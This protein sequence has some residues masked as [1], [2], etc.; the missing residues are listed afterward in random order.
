MDVE[1]PPAL[2]EVPFS[3]PSVRGAVGG[4]A[5]SSSL[6]LLRLNEFESPEGADAGVAPF[7]EPKPGRPVLRLFPFDDTAPL[8]P[9]V[10]FRFASL[11]SDA[12]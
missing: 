9:A 4:L 3:V 1:P 8:L 10:A 12:A 2:C 7:P 6:P 11:A 5:E